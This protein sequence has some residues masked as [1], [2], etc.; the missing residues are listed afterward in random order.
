M[1][2]FSI[3][4]D[5]DVFENIPWGPLFWSGIYAGK[6]ILPLRYGRSSPL[7]RYREQLPFLLAEH[8]IPCFSQS[9]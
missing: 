8:I 3:I 7:R 1:Q 6:L 9:S 2:P 5:F 4:K